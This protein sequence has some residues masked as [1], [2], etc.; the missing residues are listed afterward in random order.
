MSTLIQRT[1]SGTVYVAVIVGSILVPNSFFFALLCIVLSILGICELIQLSG[2]DTWLTWMSAL[3]GVCIV[4]ITWIAS[5]F[6]AETMAGRMDDE[7]HSEWLFIGVFCALCILLIAVFFTTMIA[8]LFRKETDAL[9]NRGRYLQAVVMIGIPFATMAAMCAIRPMYLLALFVSIW[10]KDTGA[11]LVGMATSHLPGGNHKMFERIS[12]KKSWEGLIG[13]I[14]FNL[15][16]GYVFYRVGWIDAL[17]KSMVF[18]LL[19][20]LFGT[21]G[22]LIESQL[23]R[24]VGVKDSGRFM[25]GHGGVLDRFDSMLLAAPSVGISMLLLALI[26]T[27]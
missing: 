10:V 1:L 4:A 7:I 12:P 8:E 27:M 18:V 13:G 26:E 23:K 19:A 20:S 14:V 16:A 2:K 22:D 3:T 9:K 11:Y 6:F 24:S 21:L 25:P 15:L 5:Y 17:N